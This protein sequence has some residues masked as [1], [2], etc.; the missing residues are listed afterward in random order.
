MEESNTMKTFRDWLSVNI[1]PILFLSFYFLTVVLGNLLY[2]SP[3]GNWLIVTDGLPED[4]LS[5][6]TTFTLGYWVL[7]LMPFVL[8]PVGVWALRPVLAKFIVGP[9]V[10]YVPDFRSIDWVVIFAAIA[11]FAIYGLYR[12]DAFALSGNAVDAKQAIEARF[13]LQNRMSFP[14]KVA[15]HALLPFMSFYAIAALIKTGRRFWLGPVILSVGVTCTSL[16][17]INMKWP[18]LVFY[19]GAV[20]GIFMY[21]KR[22]PYL[23]AALGAAGLFVFYV[24][25]STYV[26]R[27]VP[28]AETP[29]PQVSAPSTAQPAKPTNHSPKETSPDY[30]SLARSSVQ[31]APFLVVHALNRMAISYPYYYKI[32]T[33]QGPVC[34]NLI[35]TYTPGKKP[36]APTFL[37]Y[38]H[39]FPND[40]YDGRASAPASPQ[41]TAYAQQGWTGAAIGTIFIVVVLAGF[42]AVPLAAGPMAAAFAIV[43]ATV[44][45]HYSQLPLEGPITYDHGFLWPLLLIAVYTF[46]WKFFGGI[47]RDLRAKSV[48]VAHPSKRGGCNSSERLPEK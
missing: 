23:K 8:V 37:V 11:G 6:D 30:S 16:V 3:I 43:G 47:V 34:G 42:S 40:G 27:W 17:A 19:M 39:I 2:A 48:R 4:A 32:F 25:I 1:G 35:E 36:C 44:G 9:I 46:F 41:V 28:A 31:S 13:I 45:Y 5:F 33:E 21:S 12:T 22:W 14:E 20:A 10:R 38:S 24:V 7:L 18:V 29:A 15:I 26:F